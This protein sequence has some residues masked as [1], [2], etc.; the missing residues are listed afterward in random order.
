M[1]GLGQIYQGR[2][3]K[4]VLFFVAIYALFFYGMY[5]GSG[6][7]KA[8]EPAKTYTVSGPV[9]LP[10]ASKQNAPMDG[11]PPLAND[12]YNRP[13]YLGQFWVGIVAWPA[14]WQYFNYD[15]NQE[16][17]TALGRFERTPSEEALNAVHTE[18][19]KLIDLGWVYTV[20][21]GVLNI[22][23][24]YDALAGPALLARKPEPL[25]KATA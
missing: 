16:P 2:I 7:V 19:D 11:L 8:G 6:T 5:L 18:G 24:I 22:M 14:L 3:G 23:V 9:Y 4:G 12:L 15:K 20:I 10:E 13:Q 1:P 17:E 21:A 25:R